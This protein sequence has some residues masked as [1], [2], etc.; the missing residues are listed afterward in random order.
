[1][2]PVTRFLLK[3]A[4]AIQLTR[5]TIAFGA[6]S[7][8]W[9]IIL[10]TRGAPADAGRVPVHDLPLWISLACGA[11]V[12][13]GLFAYGAALND[14]L[15]LRHDRAFSPDRPL[16]AGRIRLGQAVVVCVAALL[17][18]VLAS[19]VFGQW[20]VSVTLLTAAGLLF[21]NAI[22][23]YIPP[24]S[25]VTVGLVH[26]V[27]MFIPNV[28]IQ[29]TLPIWMIMTHAMVIALLVHILEEKRPRIHRRSIIMIVVGW[30]F[31][32]AFVLG[33]AGWSPPGGWPDRASLSALWAPLLALAG[34]VAVA[35]WKVRRVAEP[36]AAA[37]KL[38][39]YGAMWQ[40]LY[41]AAWLIVLDLQSEAAFISLFAVAGFAV[42]TI[43]KELTGYSG[44]PL[45]YRA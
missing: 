1:M 30:M 40:S 43:L 21:Y 16:P 29:F 8:I 32:S 6:V 13:V 5:L 41:G 9:F 31:W 42:M 7:D 33:Y 22:G 4:T 2:P 37:E 14:I 10:A 19:I 28:L 23:K 24:V 34:F 17:I 20:S 35:S 45:R 38:R 12:A 25:V 39:R 15:D 18:A 26:A 11:V 36:P 3:L 44:A 27:H